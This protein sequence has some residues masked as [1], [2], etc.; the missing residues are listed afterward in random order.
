[1]PRDFRL[2]E[3]SGDLRLGGVS[4]DGDLVLKDRDGDVLFY[5]DATD[6][7]AT[8]GGENGREVDG[9]LAVRDRDGAEVVTLDA[10]SGT[11]TVGA[12]DQYGTLEVTNDAGEATVRVD[13]DRG[14]V[15]L[16]SVG[17]LSEALDD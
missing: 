15:W 9:S 17:W 7:S 16:A 2:D 1:V 10:R 8:V 3:Q 13:G 5:L 12:S 11:V 6:G 14:D 4:A